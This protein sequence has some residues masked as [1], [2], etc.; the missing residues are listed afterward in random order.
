MNEKSDPN[1]LMYA[2]WFQHNSQLVSAVL[3]TVNVPTVVLDTAG[4][5]I[6]FNLTCEHLSGYTRNQ[7]RGKN[8]WD[9]LSTSIA[10]KFLQHSLQM[11]WKSRRSRSYRT[12]WLTREGR[13]YFIDWL[14][15][16]VL[17]RKHQ[18]EYIVLTGT[19]ANNRDTL[20]AFP[21]Q[22]PA[23][24]PSVSEPKSHSHEHSSQVATPIEPQKM[25]DLEEMLKRITEQIR[26][27]LDDDSLLQT[28]VKELGL[29]FDLDAC[30]LETYNTDH[31]V[32][33]LHHTYLKPGILLPQPQLR[34][35]NWDDLCATVAQRNAAQ[36]CLPLAQPTQHPSRSSLAS[37]HLGRF[38]ILVCLI[39]SD[40]CSLGELWLLKPC[41]QVFQPFEIQIAQQVASLCAIAIRQAKLYQSTQTQVEI[42]AQLNR[43]Q[44]EFLSRVSHELR[45]PIS[46]IKMATQM[47]G[48]ALNRELP[49]FAELSKPTHERN[50]IAQYFQILHDECE[51]EISLINDLLDL[52]R[53]ETGSLPPLLEPID[54]NSWLPS[55]VDSF[56]GRIRNRKQTLAVLISPDLPAILSVPR[57]LVRILTELLDNACKYTPAEGH[58]TFKGWSD[59]EAIFFQ[60]TNSGI[61]IPPDQISR[62]FD[63]FYRIA[64]PDPWEQGG[65]GLGLALALK[66][67]KR[68]G[69]TL[70]ASSTS[71]QT[72]FIFKLPLGGDV[73]STEDSQS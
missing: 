30:Y 27:Q 65:T 4:Q 14:A 38:T 72:S 46:N 61:E 11:T 43:L 60:V 31:T 39:K 71:G 25:L 62:I 35:E 20:P 51:R 7:V 33:T 23:I 69:G 47:L 73:K 16:P 36:C 26:D 9:L 70:T 55:I 67:A 44:D 68:L 2:E 42:F 8:F 28:A 22:L 32:T 21:P 12:C 34:L 17:N 57:D 19:D 15:T 40:R 5:I 56:K 50:K 29:A 37:Y 53:F 52:Q 48:I 59:G 3:D 64:N 45:T 49:L 63:K 1:E 54:L 66:L 41:D 10:D 24:F 6:H 13:D 18:I 58:I